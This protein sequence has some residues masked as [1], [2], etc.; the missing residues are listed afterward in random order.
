MKVDKDFLVRLKGHYQAKY[1]IEIDSWL[2]VILFEIDER[3]KSYEGKADNSIG[4]IQIAVQNF[5]GKKHEV[6]FNHWKQAFY[7]G[8]GLAIPFSILGIVITVLG[9]IL[10]VNSQTYTEK[11][12]LIKQYPN[13]RDYKILMR[14]GQISIENGSNYLILKP[15][16]KGGDI[17]IGKE[18]YFD[19]KTK[20]VKVPLGRD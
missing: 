19:N 8:I 13:T 16:P 1:G 17:N 3:I 7:Y 14:N 18:Y 15:V 20:T 4:E 2:A 11:M 9:Y 10:V 6:F 12:E 5:K